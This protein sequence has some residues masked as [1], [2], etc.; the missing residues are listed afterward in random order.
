MSTMLSLKLWTDEKMKKKLLVLSEKR[1]YP[2]VDLFCTDI[3]AEIIQKYE[4]RYGGILSR[5]QV[6]TK[7]QKVARIQKNEKPLTKKIRLQNGWIR[8][9]KC[10]IC[11]TIKMIR[12]SGGRCS[13]CYFQFRAQITE[14]VD[15]QK[16]QE[17]KEAVSKLGLPI[18]DNMKNKYYCNNI[19]C[20]NKGT[21]YKRYELIERAN[22]LYCSEA[23]YQKINLIYD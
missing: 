8:H 17:E 22:K 9:K 13:R 12:F 18:P 14:K 19:F 2:I 1:N 20:T 23:C 21:V 3:I 7:V 10:K 15:S 5:D 16:I 11:G 4:S 6:V